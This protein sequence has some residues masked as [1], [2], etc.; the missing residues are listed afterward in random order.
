[1]GEL[2]EN[3]SSKTSEQPKSLAF[4]L[5]WMRTSS[6][7]GKEPFSVSL[8]FP[9]KHIS[10]ESQPGSIFLLESSISYMSE[11]QSPEASALVPALPLCGL[12]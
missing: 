10:P 11:G 2:P 1:M 9:S 6:E 7:L 5:Y 12:G 3:Q 4:H 8:A